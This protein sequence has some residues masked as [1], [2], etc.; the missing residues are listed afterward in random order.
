MGGPPSG[1]PVTLNTTTA[2]FSAAPNPYNMILMTGIELDTSGVLH[3]LAFAFDPGTGAPQ[4]PATYLIDGTT[5]IE[6]KAADIKTLD[7]DQILGALA[8]PGTRCQ[9]EPVVP[10]GIQRTPTFTG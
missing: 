2:A 3:G 5:D 10:P 6:T 8:I 4:S 7:P 1:Q 9:S